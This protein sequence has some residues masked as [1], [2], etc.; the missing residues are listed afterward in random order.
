[1]AKIFIGADDEMQ[2]YLDC[3]ADSKPL[4]REDEVELAKRIKR[5]DET[6][7]N[8]LVEANLR[9]VVSIAKQ[10]QHRGLTL[11]EIISAGNMGLLEAAGRFDGARGFKF[12]S[13]A[14]WWI[15]QA[16]LQVLADQV[17]TVRLPIN[18]LALLKDISE[19]SRRLSQTQDR[20]PDIEA[21][22]AELDMSPKEVVEVLRDGRTIRSLD[23]PFDEYDGRT[24]L[25]LLPDEAQAPPDVAALDSSVIEILRTEL[26]IL[27]KREQKIL[28]LYYGLDGQNPITLEKIGGIMSLTRERIRQ[29]K[30][31]ALAKLRDP[32]RSRLREACGL[33]P[34]KSPASKTKAG[35]R[36]KKRM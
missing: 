5:G 6:A 8:K 16:I 30:E 25:N 35:L 13:Y 3:I 1:M 36:N 31:R 29:L 9:F 10:Y 26:E 21:V 19:A 14:V 20:E 28:R 33:P 32:S 12:I 34:G 24:L 23:E 18:R 2:A 4:S 11:M 17:R 7:R 15:R 27:D 22:A